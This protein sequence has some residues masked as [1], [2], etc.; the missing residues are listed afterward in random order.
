MTRLAVTGANGFIARHLITLARTR[1]YEV[2][3][4]VR[5]KQAARTA[6]LSGA[7]PV[8]VPA[9]AADA[10]ASAFADCAAVVHLAQIGAER[11]GE[12][13]EAVNV[14]GTRAVIAAARAAGAPPIGWFSCPGLAHYAI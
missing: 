1:G 9:L 12:S 13:Y 5:S 10:L 2:H 8:I 7:H 3:G 14:E 4:V 11:G 6:I